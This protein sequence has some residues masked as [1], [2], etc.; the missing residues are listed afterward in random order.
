MECQTDYAVD[1]ICQI[2]RRGKVSLDVKPE[3]LA[4]FTEDVNV[5]LKERIFEGPTCGAW[6]KS[7]R[8]IMWPMFATKL[9]WR[10]RAC[11]LR[12]YNVK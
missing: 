11:D 5:N 6:Y 10:T 9:W 8:Y 12:E 7:Y 2:I 3:A 1:A 4:A